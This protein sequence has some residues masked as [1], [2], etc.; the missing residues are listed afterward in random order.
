MVQH[1][2]PYTTTGKTIA[3]TRRTFVGK[4]MSLLFNMLSSFVRL[5]HHI[6]HMAAYFF[7]FVMLT[8]SPNDFFLQLLDELV[9]FS[10]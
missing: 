9:R 7:P 2:H 6:M 5:I 10:A 4:E 8:L 3:S 1:S